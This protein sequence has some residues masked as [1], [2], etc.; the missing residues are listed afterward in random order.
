MKWLTNREAAALM[1][2]HPMTL[3]KWRCERRGPRFQKL[4]SQAASR[5][6]YLDREVRMYMKDPD[7]YEA[8][9]RRGVA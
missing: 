2:I 9:N 6:R 4:G 5:V 7:G 8:R 1:G 3:A